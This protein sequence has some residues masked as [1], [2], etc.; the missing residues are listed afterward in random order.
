[1]QGHT[2]QCLSQNASSIALRAPY[3]PLECVNG[4]NAGQLQQWLQRSFLPA[5]QNVQSHG[6]AVETPLL[7]VV[8]NALSHLT[9]VGTKRDFACGL[10]Q[11]L[12]ANVD[13]A[14][15]QGL[16]AEISRLMGEPNVLI[17]SAV[18]DPA[19]LRCC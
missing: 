19:A 4:V 17:G 3:Q 5:L 11:G 8:R 16:A 14:G 18:A 1:M 13:E 10:F 9:G 6:L 12:G 2:C 7:A 15:R